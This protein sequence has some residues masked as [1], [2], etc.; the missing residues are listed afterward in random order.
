[1]TA[2]FKITRQLLEDI[3]KDLSRPHHFAFERVGFLFVK[4][5]TAGFTGI[6]GQPSHCNHTHHVSIS[7]LRSWYPRLFSW[8]GSSHQATVE[9]PRMRKRIA[10]SS[11]V[12]GELWLM[13]L[14]SSYSPVSD[15]DYI[16]D[17]TVGA[18]IGSAAIRSAM[19]RSLDTGVGVMHVH[20]H[21]GMGRPGFSLTD[22]KSM[23]VLMPSFFN[24]SPNVPH[25]ALLFN[26]DSITGIVW[27]DKQTALPISRVSIVGYPC[28]FDK[29]LGYV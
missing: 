22:R 8:F 18:K 14:A 28:S 21:E 17:H 2:H 26:K 20:M 3:R 29:G 7:L 25:G 16:K 19:Q 4:S 15:G 27:K 11:K 10:S 13:I 5:A 12:D 24:V 9:S 1:M 6:Q 23:N